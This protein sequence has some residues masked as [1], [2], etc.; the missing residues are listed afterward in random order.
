MDLTGHQ[1]LPITQSI[2]VE[3]G[4]PPID[5]DYASQELKPGTTI[6]GR[7]SIVQFIGKGGMGS[8]YKVKHLSLGKIMAMKILWPTYATHPIHRLRF[9]VE[10]TAASSLDHANL[11]T[12]RDFGI[13]DHSTPYL[14]MDYVEGD[15]LSALIEGQG[16]LPWTSCLE[17]AIQIC[18]AL[19]HAHEMGVVHR[20]LKPNNIL[21]TRTK[22]GEE[23]IKIVDFG[24]AKLHSKQSPSQSVTKTGEIFGSPLY[25]SPEQCA[26]READGRSDIYS[27]GCLIYEALCG[28]PPFVGE[29]SVSTMFKHLNEKP[30]AI[31]E[32]VR[33]PIPSALTNIVYRALAKD[34]ADRYQ[35]MAE[36][37]RDLE[38]VKSGGEKDLKAQK[39]VSPWFSRKR[40]YIYAC[41]FFFSVW[42]GA[43]L[44]V[45]VA[46]APLLGVPMSH[47]LE[48]LKSF[49]I[50]PPVGYLIHKGKKDNRDQ[51]SSD[52]PP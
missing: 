11:V 1:E 5:F 17:F 42:L 49:G 15:N 7:Y 13:N 9:T 34:P 45:C 23:Q 33:E 3:N 26:G 39:Q 12:V 44:A 37:Q 20:D 24:I 27:L 31:K 8:V 50:S 35:S 21:V 40:L 36:M 47:R 46:L 14:V 41:A 4:S 18:S 2:Q 43:T 28:S 19:Q 52:Q 6:A 10:A 22:Y 51:T 48:V 29:N 16:H 32:S 25:M 38:L 30:G